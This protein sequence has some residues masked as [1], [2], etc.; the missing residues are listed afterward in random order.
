MTMR[1]YWGVER[2]R[3][4]AGILAA[5]LA[6]T[7]LAGVV[8]GHAQDADLSRKLTLKEAVN[9][10]VANSRDLA[11]ARLQYGV[12]QRQIGV[13]RSVFLPNLYTGTGVAYT[14]GFPLLEGGG[15]PAIFALSY[16]QQIFN[17]PAKG[18]QRAAEQRAE[19]QRLSMD[20]VRDAVMSR[21]ALDYLELAKV[22]HA[23]EL[24]RGE[25]MSAGRILDTT[26]ERAD[27]GRELPI[28]VIRAQLT[29]AKIE[30]RIAQLEDRE[31]ALTGELRDM[32]GLPSDEQIDV[33]TEE[34]P[35]A[36]EEASK[37]VVSDALANNVELKQ[38]QTELRAREFKLK[39][40][41]GGR[42]PSFSLIGQYNVL[43]KIN[44][45]TS[46]FDRF[47]RNNVVFGVQVQIPIF[48][49]RTSSAVAFARADY[50]AATLALR[51]KRSEVTLDVRRKARQV[52]E[53][54][55]GGD[56]ARLELQLTQENVRVLQAQFD[57]GRGSLKD[58]EAAHIEEN[59]KWL[60]FL[61]A[62]YAR[63]QAQLDL[64]RATGQLA[65]VLQ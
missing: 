39:G 43:S 32:M 17:P 15:A 1:H 36:A 51:N 2:T 45:Y 60:A 13:A 3:V 37:D 59:D 9:L 22:R 21:A 56:V 12:T 63:Q 24:M 16:S 52:R 62:N 38:A 58:L 65:Q 44:N 11:L 23:L 6:I 18:E 8:P 40:E 35:G 26:R 31:D 50:N 34:I 4:R 30:Q 20:D 61:D 64:L 7:L 33:S 14:S 5:G 53:A 41:Q 54:D 28:E 27:T 55:L 47:S 49:S 29:T 25:R 57:Q 42:W 46:Y 48:A 10:A 19:E